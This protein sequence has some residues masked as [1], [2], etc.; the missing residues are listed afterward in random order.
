M[1]WNLNYSLIYRFTDSRLLTRQFPLTSF[2]WVNWF[3]ACMRVYR[4]WSR[5]L[6]DHGHSQIEKVKEASVQYVQQTI[7][8]LQQ[9]VALD[10]LKM[11]S[12]TSALQSLLWSSRTQP[13]VVCD[14]APVYDPR[15]QN[16]AL[17]P[18][19]LCP[20][21]VCVFTNKSSHYTS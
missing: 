4:T 7:I 15:P 6:L 9:S 21:S 20:C 5:S 14:L 17:L 2:L 10:F 13:E 3:L 12:S 11:H 8:I 19:C 1:L 18:D 16:A